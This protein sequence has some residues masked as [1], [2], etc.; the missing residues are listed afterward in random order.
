M[1]EKKCGKIINVSSI[2]GRFRSKMAGMHYSCAKSAIITLTKQLAAEV[3]S[4]NI[5]VNTVC[6]SQT[7]TEMLE[8]FLTGDAEKNLKSS[9]PLGYIA[10]P[11]QQAEVI[12]F[13]ASEQSNY[14]TGAIVDV[15]GGQL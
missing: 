7:K 12:L 13:L 4:Y 3:G 5:N 10:A 9:I 15:N 2:A 11:E 8:P 6:P 14:M 1:K